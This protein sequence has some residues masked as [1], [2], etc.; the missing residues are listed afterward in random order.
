MSDNKLIDTIKTGLETLKVMRLVK[1]NSKVSNMKLLE[2]Y[3]IGKKLE[4]HGKSM[5]SNARPVITARCNE[6]KFKSITSGRHMAN[7]VSKERKGI[8]TKLVYSLMENGVIPTKY[9][10]E[11]VKITPY[12]SVMF[13]V[14]EG[15]VDTSD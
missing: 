13:Q 2:Y 12:N 4:K 10:E 15:E 7:L 8:N 3:D 6:N 9:H 5:Q 14:V 1:I 11:L